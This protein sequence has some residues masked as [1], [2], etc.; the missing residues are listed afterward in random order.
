[1][2][3]SLSQW[4]S[5]WQFAPRPESYRDFLPSLFDF[6]LCSQIEMLIR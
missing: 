5:V 6:P 1:M 3:Q 2:P 4:Q